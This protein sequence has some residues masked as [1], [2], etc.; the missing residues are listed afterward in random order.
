MCHLRQTNTIIWSDPILGADIGVFILTIIFVSASRRT[1]IPAWYMDKI[2]NGIKDGYIDVT[3]RFKRVSRVSLSP[4]D[5]KCFAWWSKDYS[6]WLEYYHQNRQAFDQYKHYFNFTITGDSELEKG[7]KSNLENRLQQLT[8]LAKLFG[9]IAIQLRFDPIVIYLDKKT[10][11]LKDNLGE[12]PLIVKTAGHLGIKKI[13]FAFCIGSPTYPRVEKRM[14]DIGHILIPMSVDEQK[15][16]LDPLIDLSEVYGI[17]LETCCGTP[18]IGYRGIKSTA[19]IDADVID[20]L[21]G[22]KL[23]AHKKDTGQ[24]KLCNCVA[25]KDIGSYEL[26]CYHDCDYCYASPASK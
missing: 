11:Q 8:E 6:K 22:Y 4:K 18:F 25:S 17:H 3:D 20:Q 16:V 26:K 2:I 10:N 24:R 7:V 14:K 9:P 21:L 1:D 5:V 19:C 23:S 12:Y 13:I 15:K